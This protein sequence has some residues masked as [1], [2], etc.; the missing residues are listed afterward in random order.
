[1]KRSIPRHP[2]VPCFLGAV[3]YVAKNKKKHSVGC[4]GTVDK[5]IQWIFSNGGPGRRAA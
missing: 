5:M 4:P 1:M 2:K 3:S